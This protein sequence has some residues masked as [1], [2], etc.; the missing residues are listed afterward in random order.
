LFDFYDLTSHLGTHDVDIDV[1]DS[2]LAPN[3]P[4][5]N[6]EN[7]GDPAPGVL[8]QN[9]AAEAGDVDPV[10][11]NLNTGADVFCYTSA[12]G[13]VMDGAFR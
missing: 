3:D 1:H 6:L 13:S 5:A 12:D 7:S 11:P 9:P 10:G 4:D 8:V 2:T